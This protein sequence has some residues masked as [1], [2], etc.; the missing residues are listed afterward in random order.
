MK[1]LMFTIY[2]LHA[3]YTI[4]LRVRVRQVN[5]LFKM[6]LVVLLLPL[7]QKC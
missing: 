7:A 2:T 5:L 1:T 3:Y 4:I 6:L